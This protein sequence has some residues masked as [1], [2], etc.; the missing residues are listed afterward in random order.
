M[1][2]NAQNLFERL[3]LTGLKPEQKETMLKQFAE[4]LTHRISFKIFEVLTPEQQK[5]FD[6]L[7][8]KDQTKADQY[9]AKTIPNLDEIAKTETEKLITE[10]QTQIEQAKAELTKT[11]A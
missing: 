6:T 4:I 11:N 5:E 2:Q 3:N 7:Q 1:N 8:E 10:M 9:L